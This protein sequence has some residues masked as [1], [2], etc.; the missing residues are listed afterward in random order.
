MFASKTTR[1][2]GFGDV[3]VTIRKLSAVRLEEALRARQ[4]ALGE[5]AKNLGK[6]ELSQEA[7]EQFKTKP[8][9]QTEDEKKEARNSLYD[10]MTVLRYG[11]ESWTAADSVTPELLDDLEEPVAR[12]LFEQIMDLTFE[13]EETRKKD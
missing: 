5:I 6:L 4:K 8:E 13:D 2:I 10:R 11:I 1:A 12:R 7:L 9:S 3:T